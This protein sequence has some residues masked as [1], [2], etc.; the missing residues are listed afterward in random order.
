M[1]IHVYQASRENLELMRDAFFYREDG[2]IFNQYQALEAY[3]HGKYKLVATVD[4]D[5][6]EEV[7]AI[8]NSGAN[9]IDEVVSYR[10]YHS[11]SV[12]DILVDADQILI[13]AR[14]GFDNLM[15]LCR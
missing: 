11:L 9:R 10:P 1:S 15:E 2:N 5:D 8:M 12:G 13:T 3:E 4:S 7:F 14:A 6:P